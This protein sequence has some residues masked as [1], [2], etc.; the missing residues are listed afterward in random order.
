MPKI[1][2]KRKK[3]IKEFEQMRNLAELRALSSQSLKRPL[4]DKEFRRMKTLSKKLNVML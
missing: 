1:D 2:A 4:T 3:A